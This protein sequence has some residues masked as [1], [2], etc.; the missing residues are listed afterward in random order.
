[1]VKRKYY[2][3]KKGDVIRTNPE[4][5]FYGVAVVLDDGKRLEEQPGKFSCPMCHIAITPLIYD[6][7]ITMDDINIDKLHP[8]IFQRCFSLKGK[9]EFYREELLIHIYTTRNIIDQPIIGNVVPNIVYNGELPWEPGGDKFHWCGDI[10]AMFGREAYT[11]WLR[12]KGITIQES[13]IVTSKIHIKSNGD[14]Y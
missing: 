7:E 2:E 8:L 10:G 9:P 13:T 12:N 1:M 5:G 14:G 6:Y 4:E 11:Q 3:F